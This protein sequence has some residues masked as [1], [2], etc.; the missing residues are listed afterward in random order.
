MHF[1]R[2]SKAGHERLVFQV[3]EGRHE[4]ARGIAD[5]RGW[6]SCRRARA[7]RTRSS[8]AATDSSST[9]IVR[10]GPTGSSTRPPE[11]DKRRQRRFHLRGAQ[12]GECAESALGPAC[13]AER[14]QGAAKRASGSFERRRSSRGDR[15]LIG[16]S[17]PRN[18]GRDHAAAAD[19]GGGALDAQHKRLT[20]HGHDR[21]GRARAGRGGA[22][23][24]ASRFAR[25]A[26]GR[27]RLRPCRGAA[28]SGRGA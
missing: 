21:L 6:A 15:R 25:A 14:R 22:C 8:S 16:A 2:S 28:C 11:A 12:A 27:P 5:C 23:P 13:L 3:G 26:R 4:L 24:P 1:K 17:E 19:R 20:V 10:R 9:R 18:D 7:R